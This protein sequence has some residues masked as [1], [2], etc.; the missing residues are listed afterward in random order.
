MKFG[1]SSCEDVEVEHGTSE[2]RNLYWLR[3]LLDCA[4][5]GWIQDRP[6]RREGDRN[7]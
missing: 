4:L 6:W 3:P 7:R 1:P 2:Y 5:P